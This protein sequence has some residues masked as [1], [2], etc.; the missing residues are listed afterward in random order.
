MQIS[1]LVH[2]EYRSLKQNSL[3]RS[4]DH[5]NYTQQQIG[6]MHD[7]I[8]QHRQNGQAL[9]QSKAAVDISLFTQMQKN[10]YEVTKSHSLQSV[11]ENYES[12]KMI[13]NGDAGTCKSCLLNT[14]RSLLEDKCSYN[15]QI[16]S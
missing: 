4:Q 8:P 9:Q 2:N 6:E 7:W 11:D 15:R 12:L 1:N 13:I 10:T 16:S 5:S 3:E 14:I